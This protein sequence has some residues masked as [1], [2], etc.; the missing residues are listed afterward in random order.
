[1][2]SPENGE[3]VKAL[4][5]QVVAYCLRN[6]DRTMSHA[7]TTPLTATLS[8]PH[9]VEDARFVTIP[10]VLVHL[11][12]NL[13]NDP[14]IQDDGEPA[15][16][17]DYIVGGNGIVKALQ[18]FLSEEAADLRRGSL[19][20]SGTVTPIER[21]EHAGHEIKRKGKAKEVSKELLESARKLR[22]RL[23][24]ALV[25]EFTSGDEINYSKL[26][27]SLLRIY[28]MLTMLRTVIVFGRHA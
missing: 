4:A 9:G 16:D 7:I 22:A 21:H 11:V 25:K 6:M 3:V 28:I 14:K 5:K 23:Q 24:P 26:V 19:S 20:A 12:G 1:M 13:E 18:Y 10:D 2:P 17:E 27:K 8:K 15:P